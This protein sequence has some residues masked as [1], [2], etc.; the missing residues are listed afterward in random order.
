MDG[1]V[2]LD[3][4]EAY[5]SSDD[6][7]EEC[8]DLSEL[9]GFLAGLVVGPETIPPSEWMP[10][11]WDNEEPA[12]A[13]E[14][15]A[16]TI[17]STI[18]GRYN[19]IVDSLDTEPA[20]YAPVFWQDFTGATIVEDWA[21]G[22]MQAVSLRQIAWEPVLGDDDTAML[23]IP[24]AAIAGLAMPDGTDD[25]LSLPDEVMDKL[26]EE[27]PDVL[28]SCVLGLRIFW[29]DRLLPPGSRSRRH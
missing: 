22:F 12:F 21:I 10:A 3:A 18:L 27:A 14:A 8:M 19:E 7:P 2:D 13:D 4:L 9:D 25:E 24:I 6:S 1:T 16:N 23:L 15:Q 26:V 5:L 17:L 11:V 28:P 29:R 20:E